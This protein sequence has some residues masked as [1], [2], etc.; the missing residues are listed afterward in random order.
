VIEN[1]LSGFMNDNGQSLFT[2]LSFP[3]QMQ[4]KSLCVVTDMGLC[5]F[6]CSLL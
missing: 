5:F 4:S 2:Q 6:F 3:W 1:Y